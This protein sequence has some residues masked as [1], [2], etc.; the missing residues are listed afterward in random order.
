M[1][2]VKRGAREFRFHVLFTLLV[3]RN[4]LDQPNNPNAVNLRTQ[5]QLADDG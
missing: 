3:S 4:N 5:R 1:I 2:Y